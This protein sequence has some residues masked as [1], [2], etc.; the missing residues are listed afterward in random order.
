MAPLCYTTKFDALL[1]L[2]C[3]PPPWHN[4]RKGRDQILPSGNFG[5]DVYP[6]PATMAKLVLPDETD[7]DTIANPSLLDKVSTQRRIKM[8]EFGLWAERM[9]GRG[10]YASLSDVIKE[11]LAIYESEGFGLRGNFQARNFSAEK[12]CTGSGNKTCTW[13]RE[14]ASCSCLSV[15]PGYCLAKSAYFISRPCKFKYFS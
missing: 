2:D 11:E 4:P 10:K 9:V 7:N 1:S 8:L 15:L 13:L 14:I 12:Y 6:L 5:G 3:A